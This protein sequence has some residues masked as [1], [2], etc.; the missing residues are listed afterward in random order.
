MCL[1]PCFIWLISFQLSPFPRCNH[2]ISCFFLSHVNSYWFLWTLPCQ[3]VPICA[4]QGSPPPSPLPPL[5]YTY[6]V[7]SP[8][9][10]QQL[11][12]RFGWEL[13]TSSW[14]PAKRRAGFLKGVKWGFL[15]WVTLFHMGKSDRRVICS[16]CRV[17]VPPAVFSAPLTLEITSVL[18]HLMNSP[19]GCLFHWNSQIL[20]CIWCLYL[21]FAEFYFFRNQVW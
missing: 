19:L 15:F 20:P 6:L 18:P 12:L 9:P 17:C 21:T 8:R 10:W 7:S 5:V 16:M 13:I 1:L 4:P 3:K 11:V 14:S 2:S